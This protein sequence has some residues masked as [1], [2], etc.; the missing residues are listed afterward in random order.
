MHGLARAD[1]KTGEEAVSHGWMGD[2]SVEAIMD[3]LQLSGV[4]KDDRQI[5]HVNALKCVSFNNPRAE[6]TLLEIDANRTMT[7]EL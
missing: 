2:L 3:C 5:I 1:I 7:V 4:I 6:I